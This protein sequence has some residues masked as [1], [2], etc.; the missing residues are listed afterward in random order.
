MSRQP[1]IQ[2]IIVLLLIEIKSESKNNSI[3]SGCSERQI[4]L[5]TIVANFNYMHTQY[6]I[7]Y[8]DSWRE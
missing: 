3:L 2:Y 1:P 6:M 8:P 4:L 5:L 7:K